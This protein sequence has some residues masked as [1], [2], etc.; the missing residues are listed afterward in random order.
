[1]SGTPEQFTGFFRSHENGL[2]SRFLIYT[3]Q[4]NPH[5][6]TCAP[7]EGR[8]DLRE[9][10]HTLGKKL[11]EMHKLLL[12]S[13]TLVTFT[14]GQW[15][16]H[17]QQFGVWLKSA[18]VEGKEFPTSIVFRHGLLAMRLASI[19]TIFRKWDDYRYAKEYC[20]TDADFDTAMQI[21]A[22]VIE[23]S[24]LL[25]TSLPDTG[26][27]PVAMRKF[28]QFE[29]VLKKLPRIFSYIDFINS[30]KEL[31]ISVSTAKRYLRKAVEQELVV[32]QKD[33]YRKR[34]KR[35]GKQG[36]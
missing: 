22:T 20:C 13:P 18:L 24:L 4:L 25:G 30:A 9:H 8:V 29:D 17:T 7:G 21:I 1:M 26:H 12:E 31:G 2:Y 6:E 36:L 19:L 14:P 35:Q 11:F 16:R 33:K 5:W 15:E 23:H 27:P 10:F 32:K 3:R 28:H 34:R